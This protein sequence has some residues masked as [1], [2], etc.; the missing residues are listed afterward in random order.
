MIYSFTISEYSDKLISFYEVNNNKTY[1]DFL[2]ESL[3]I[4][5]TNLIIE[6]YSEEDLIYALEYA[7]ELNKNSIE[8]KWLFSKKQFNINSSMKGLGERVQCVYNIPTTFY[9]EIHE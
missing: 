7:L 1:R 2:M 6:H 3:S 8:F 9:K 4:F 5:G